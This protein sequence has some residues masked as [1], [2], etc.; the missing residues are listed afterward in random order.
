MTNLI[1]V[2]TLERY[3]RKLVRS[4]P[5]SPCEPIDPLLNQTGRHLIHTTLLKLAAFLSSEN[6]VLIYVAALQSLFKYAVHD[7]VINDQGQ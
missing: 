1:K 4:R 7:E 5:V 2:S 6:V 3:L